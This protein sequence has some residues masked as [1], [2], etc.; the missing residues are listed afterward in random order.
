[1]GLAVS[2]LQQR[3]TGTAF[4]GV[5]VSKPTRKDSFAF[6][7]VS[8]PPTSAEEL[9][10]LGRQLHRAEMQRLKM[11]HRTGLGGR[12]VVL[13][14]SQLMDQLVLWS[15][16][17]VLKQSG[18]KP[19]VSEGLAIVAL[20]GY[21]RQELAPYSDVDLMFLKKGRQSESENLMVQKMLCL[22]WDMGF[23]VG[24]SVRSI[25]DALNIA[26]EDLVSQ[27]S[28]LDARLITG[29]T[30]LFEEFS[31]RMQ[32]ATQRN[33]RKFQERLFGSIQERHAG[34][35]GTAFIQEPNVKE[36]K[37]GLRDFHCAGWIARALYPGQTLPEILA[38]DEISQAD[39]KRA[40]S[41][42]EFLQHLRNELHFLTGRRNDTLSHAVL[43]QVVKHFGFR[44]NKFQKDS[45]AFLK[46]YY[47]Q[48]RRVSQVLET[49]MLRCQRETQQKPKWSGGR[50]F[51]IRLGKK[52]K[53]EL[54]KETSALSQRPEKWM[55][56]FRYQQSQGGVLDETARMAIRQNLQRFN[57]AAFSTSSLA[58]DFRA[59]LRNKGHVARCHSPDARAGF[60]GKSI[61]GVRQADLLGST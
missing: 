14:R 27:V 28:M 59:I 48:A 49:V 34:Q 54:G 40:L 61:A 8:D 3:I 7:A 5:T 30:Q 33:R 37:G 50:Y 32:L 42:Y 57:Q 53:A 52:Q 13:F 11:R 18:I 26:Q 44:G 6:L 31:K 9:L 43:S 20:G 24:H 55:Q 58:A 41:A 60:S 15:Y 36:A 45:E 25:K 19:Q 51:K 2:V 29:D 35:G 21:G 4:P 39:W 22:L 38:E 17:A 10:D 16:Q 1:M 12:E 23:Q 47:I 46:H 56:H